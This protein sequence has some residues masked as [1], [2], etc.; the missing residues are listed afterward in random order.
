VLGRICARL[1]AT[2]RQL[3]DTRA[4]KV[5]CTRFFRNDSVTV[6]EIVQTAAARTAQ[7][8]AG[9]DVLLIE[10]TSEVNYQSK[11]ARKRK[12]GRVGNGTDAGLFVHPVLAVDAGDGSV[13]GLAGALVWRRTKAKQ[14][15]YQS[16]P[17]ETKESYRWIAA[18]KTAQAVIAAASRVTVI[19]DREAD[20][21]ELFARLPAEGADMLVRATHDRAL[22]DKGRLF[23]EIAARDE[24]GR[25]DFEMP[26]RPGRPARHVTLAVRFAPVTLAQPRRGASSQDPESVALHLVEVR[27][28]DPPSTKEAVLWRLLTTHAIASFADA[29]H[30]VDLYRRRWSIEQLFRTLKSQGIDLEESLLADGDA[31]ERLAA[32][33]LVAATKVMQLV[34]GR[35]EAGHNL[36]A[37]RVFDP[38]EIAFLRALIPTLE[39]KTAKQKNSHPPDTLAWAAWCIARLGGW[40]G[41]STERPPGPIT[42][43][44]GLK[45]FHAMARGF[46]I[47]TNQKSKKDV[48]SR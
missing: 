14:A 40:T 39:G 15:D 3:A 47:A 35:D 25:L 42:F 1:S 10:D 30:M 24:A 44:H 33:S 31:L 32:A 2:M 5:G 36:Q 28:I 8:A 11:V 17:I 23:A 48:C 37:A 16:Q 45:Q 13:L 7:A 27:E 43:V 6:E 29:A 19:A 18:P 34:Q 22:A 12:L 46:A 38:A 26:A 9:R 21:Y 41:Y 4:E 20:I